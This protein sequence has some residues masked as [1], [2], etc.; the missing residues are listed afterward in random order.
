MKPPTTK[1]SKVKAWIVV[2]TR[3]KSIRKLSLY[4][5][6]LEYEMWKSPHKIIPCTISY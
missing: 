2:N 1:T 5:D 6:D 4:K 3:T